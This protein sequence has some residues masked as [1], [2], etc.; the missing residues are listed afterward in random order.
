MNEGAMRRINKWGFVYFD[1]MHRLQCCRLNGK[2]RCVGVI[3]CNVL[4]LLYYW[5]VL[6]CACK[7]IRECER[8]NKGF[9]RS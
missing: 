6:L 9:R 2:P 8:H 1:Q 4:L 7:R 3:E 5:G